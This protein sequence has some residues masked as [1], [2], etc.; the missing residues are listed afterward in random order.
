MLRRGLNE[1]QCRSSPTEEHFMVLHAG[2][3]MYLLCM[4]MNSLAC[5]MLHVMYYQAFGLHGCWKL[6]ARLVTYERVSMVGLCM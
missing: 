1:A 4:S 5:C 6:Q 2:L 3:K